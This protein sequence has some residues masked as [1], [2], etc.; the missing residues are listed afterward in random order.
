MEAHSS[1]SSRRPT[2]TTSNHP[3]PSPDGKTVLYDFDPQGIMAI[4]V[5]TRNVHAL[6]L[7]GVFPVYSPDGAHIAYMN[8]TSLMIA[9]SDGT[10][11]R[12]LWDSSRVNAIMAPS[13]SADGKWILAPSP[14]GGGALVRVSD[15]TVLPLPFASSYGQLALH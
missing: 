3:A 14:S 9:N 13:F 11:A 2:G 6:G 7:Q 1:S 8:G 4:D 5:A 15:G 12:S 10:S